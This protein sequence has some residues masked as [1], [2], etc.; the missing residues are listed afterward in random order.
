[1]LCIWR[2]VTRDEWL[3]MT[4]P[5]IHLNSFFISFYCFNFGCRRTMVVMLSMPMS[6]RAFVNHHYFLKNFIFNFFFFCSVRSE[7]DWIRWI[8]TARC[9]YIQNYFN[10]K[11]LQIKILYVFRNNNNN[12]NRNHNNNNNN[13]KSQ[14]CLT[15]ESTITHCPRFVPTMQLI[16]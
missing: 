5:Y 10:F 3:A 15:V 8:T 11:W 6:T 4:T 1:M 13:N 16:K 14:V 12:N 7:L 9:K 2:R